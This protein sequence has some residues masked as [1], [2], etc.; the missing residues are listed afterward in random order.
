[1]DRRKGRSDLR[2]LRRVLWH[3]TYRDRQL[4]HT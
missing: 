1:M 4:R 3:T 2:T